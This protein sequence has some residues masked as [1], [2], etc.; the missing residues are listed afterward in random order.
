MDDVQRWL[1]V[2]AL[3]ALLGALVLIG[4]DVFERVSK[5]ARGAL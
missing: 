5:S 4:R 3:L 1:R 2:L